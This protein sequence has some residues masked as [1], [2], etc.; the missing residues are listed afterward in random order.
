M[1]FKFFAYSSSVGSAESADV[2][3]DQTS[4]EKANAPEAEMAS[5]AFVV[6]RESV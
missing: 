3:L 4:P 6:G 2:F 5:G 1:F